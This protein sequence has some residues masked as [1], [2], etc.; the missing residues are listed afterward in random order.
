[1]VM[2]GVGGGCGKGRGGG[3][4]RWGWGSGRGGVFFTGEE[5]VQGWELGKGDGA[6]VGTVLVGDVNPGVPSS[7]RSGLTDVGATLFF[8]ADDGVHGGMLWKSDG[9]GA[10]TVQV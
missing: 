8:A 7:A 9:R 5:G 10:G 1:M 4:G 2:E 6:G 3:G